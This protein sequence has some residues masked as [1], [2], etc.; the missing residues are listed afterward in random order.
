MPFSEDTTAVGLKIIIDLMTAVVVK[1]NG[2][3]KGS[4]KITNRLFLRSA[5]DGLKQWVG[6]IIFKGFIYTFYNDHNYDLMPL[7]SY[8]NNRP[9]FTL[10]KK[11][12]SYLEV[13]T[14]AIVIVLIVQWYN[15]F[16]FETFLYWTGFSVV[17]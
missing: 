3:S 12:T 5:I 15:R 10:K 6:K 13:L 16:I 7:Q 9:K 11:S 1:P 8:N 14:D 2:N 4:L 17:F